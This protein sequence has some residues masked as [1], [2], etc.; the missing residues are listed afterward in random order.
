MPLVIGGA[1]IDGG[2]GDWPYGDV[3]DSSAGGIGGLIPGN[4]GRGGINP[5]P[6][7][8]GIWTGPPGNPNGG[9]IP[10]SCGNTCPIMGGRSIGTLGTMGI[11]FAAPT[12][13]GEG[14]DIGTFA[15]EGVAPC[16]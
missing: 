6:I 11:G 8:P 1:C 3:P 15:D 9:R 12:A 7:G 2:V 5:R 10:K 16:I 14:E 4:D 13:A